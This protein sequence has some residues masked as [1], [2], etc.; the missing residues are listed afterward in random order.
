MRW[1]ATKPRD[2]ERIASFCGRFEPKLN[3]YN[4]LVCT[5]GKGEC[6]F[7]GKSCLM[8]Q[9]FDLLDGNIDVEDIE[10]IRTLPIEWIIDDLNPNVK[11]IIEIVKGWE[12]CVGEE[13][14]DEVS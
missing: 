9:L 10:I 11:E 13:D 12:E 7:D 3:D 2:W 1:N 6:P 4:Q 14:K 5:V 8:I